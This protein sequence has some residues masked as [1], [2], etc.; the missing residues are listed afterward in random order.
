[1]NSSW[2]LGHFSS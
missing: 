1:V 2:N